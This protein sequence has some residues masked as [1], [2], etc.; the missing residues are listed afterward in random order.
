MKRSPLKRSGRLRP[1]SKK[2]AL[3]L[4]EYSV[5]RK[6]FLAQNP[7]CRECGVY[8]TEVHHSKGRV[9]AMLNV[10][11]FW[12]GLC[13]AC[14]MKAHLDRRWAVDRGLM[15]KPTWMIAEDAKNE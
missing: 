1:A 5:R 12:V 4:R 13:H 8:A 7:K 3:E 14:H 9:H 6:I 15:Q 10:E 2:R 11:E